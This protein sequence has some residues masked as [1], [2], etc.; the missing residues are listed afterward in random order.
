M[1]VPTAAA[2]WTPTPAPTEVFPEEGRLVAH[3]LWVQ[4]T[5]ACVLGVSNSLVNGQISDLLITVAFLLTLVAPALLLR[6]GRV[7]AATIALVV[8]PSLA[9]YAAL[10]TALIEPVS[11]V[12]YAFAL[13]LSFLAIGFYLGAR[14]LPLAQIL[15]LACG[16][17]L[18]FT[19]TFVLLPA[20]PSLLA[21]E[22]EAGITFSGPLAH[23]FAP[24]T[25]AALDAALF[26][27]MIVPL[28]FLLL[29]ALERHAR[30]GAPPAGSL[31]P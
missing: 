30:R 28:A 18:L 20:A 15:P 31:D 10:L 13:T 6:A 3:G 29:G 8:L 16:L 22:R 23:V 11:G 17:V 2:P 21:A 9:V 19:V 26:H 14:T 7:V 25:Q 12:N 24:A 4:V 1:H 5:I 27:G